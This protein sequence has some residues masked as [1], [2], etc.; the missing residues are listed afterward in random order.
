MK[1][2][3]PPKLSYHNSETILS[4]ISPHYGNSNQGQ[5]PMEQPQAYD[6]GSQRQST[7]AAFEIG[8]VKVGLE[9]TSKLPGF[10]V[11]SL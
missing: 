9:T 7:D 3:L 1:P 5:K 11:G 2:P 8:L 4:T 6:H 10:C